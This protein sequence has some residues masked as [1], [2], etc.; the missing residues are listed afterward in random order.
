MTLVD[1]FLNRAVCDPYTPEHGIEDKAVYLAGT[2]HEFPYDVPLVID[3]VR[4][5]A[6]CL[7]W[8]SE[9]ERMP[10][11]GPPHVNGNRR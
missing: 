4:V 8:L 6:L 9:P 1:S 11:G 3:S 10:V 2:V 7:L 5:C